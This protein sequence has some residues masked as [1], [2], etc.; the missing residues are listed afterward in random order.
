VRAIRVHEPGPPSVM[1]FEEAADPE[2]GPGEVLVEIHAVG[3]NPVDTYIRSGGYSKLP[4]YPYIPGNDAAGIVRGLGAGVTG[5]AVGDRVYLVGTGLG[6]GGY[7]EQVAYS[8]KHLARIPDAITFGQAAAVNV[9]YA[10]AH[11]A[12][13]E[14]ARVIGGETVLVHGGSGGV[15]IAAIELAAAA[16]ATVIAT[17]GTERGLRLVEEHGARYAFDHGKAG[18]EEAI[19]K[20]AP[21][22]LD[23]VIENLANVNLDRDLELLARFGRIVV[24]GNRGRIE[25]NPRTILQKDAVVSGMALWNATDAEL[26]SIHATLYA[27]LS[28]G[29][30]NPVVGRELPLAEAAASHDAVLAPGAYG[31]IVLVPERR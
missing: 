5:W 13:F 17:A 3:V 18:Y 27:G 6:L 12:V 28:K 26:A 9:P 31:K 15:G 23:V 20:L 7:A 29:V 2:P 25:I 21:D 10:T 1:R 30:L 8:A 11:R 14:R 16:G 19:R 4:V 22:G 24:V